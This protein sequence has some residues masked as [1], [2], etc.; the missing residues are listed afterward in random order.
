[1]KK[2][3]CDLDGTL[4][5]T[6]MLLESFLFAWKNN[7]FIPIYCIYWLVKGGKVL[8]KSEL[9]Q[10][11][12]FD[13]NLL[14]YNQTV[15]NYLIEQK[16]LGAEIFLVSAS[17]AMIT[18]KIESIFP[19]FSP[20]EKDSSVNMAGSNKAK[21]L[22][23]IF[24]EKGFSYIGNAA[25]DLNVWKH[26]DE[27]ICVNCTRSIIKKSRKLVEDTKKHIVLSK[28]LEM[29]MRIKAVASMA[30]VHQWVK[31]LLVFTPLC[32]AHTFPTWEQLGLVA[33][34]FIS[35][36]FL[37]SSVYVLNDLLDLENDR[38]HQTKKNRAFASGKVSILSGF[39]Y[40][41]LLIA[42]SYGIASFIGIGFICVLTC[43]LI[44]TLLYSFK[45]KKVPILD[46]LTLSVLYTSR[47][48][49]GMV[50]INVSVSLWLLTFSIFFF[51][52]LAFVKRYAELNN[53]IK[54]NKTKASGRGYVAEDIT[55]V[56]Q[57]GC[58]L[59]VVSA[60]IF[61]LYLSEPAIQQTFT[62]IYVTYLSVPILLYWI[63]FV[64][65]NAH[66]G[67]MHE[68]PVVFAVKNKISLVAGLLFATTFFLGGVW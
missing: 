15:V 62:N 36:N 52:A 3:C 45:L 42:L 37:A 1:M 25:V 29:L 58:S 28:K 56:G 34:S 57:I 30:R 61:T 17:D 5:N 44:V 35:F 40:L 65:F 31:N 24:G 20:F 19:F 13:P 6:D 4:V 54:M 12:V 50:A 16:E 51:L 43:Y 7:I 53:M 55:F 60:L 63:A 9:A 22:V 59:G 48:V 66:R 68:D 11:F 64:F 39:F 21:F 18:K 10:R 49:A 38:K 32:A 46:T 2:I 8:L 23:S 27:V 67:Y 33:L 14:P 47:I 41:P 26:A